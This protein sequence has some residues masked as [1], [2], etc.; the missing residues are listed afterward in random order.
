MFGLLVAIVVLVVIDKD[1]TVPRTLQI[2]S[3]AVSTVNDE[4]AFDGITILLT[5]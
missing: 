3:A 5:A 1:E 4:D 2:I